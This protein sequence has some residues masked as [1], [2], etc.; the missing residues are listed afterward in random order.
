MAK[1]EYRLKVS[2]SLGSWGAKPE[3]HFRKT[4]L[5]DL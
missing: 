3:P 2:V 5:R 1:L 4:A